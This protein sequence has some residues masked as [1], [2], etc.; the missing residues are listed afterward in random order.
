MNRNRLIIIV[1]VV[2]LLIGLGWCN[3][4][5]FFG[6]NLGKGA[7]L[8]PK[9]VDIVTV[10][11]VP[12]MLSK[13]DFDAIQSSSN[14]A[15]GLANITV[16]NPIFAEIIKDPIAAG[17]NIENPAFVTYHR[18]P[19]EQ[20]GNYSVFIF[21]VDNAAAL[22][23]MVNKATLQEKRKLD[24]YTA[25]DIDRLSTVGWTNKYLVFIT[26]DLI[27]DLDEKLSSYL[28]NSTQNSILQEPTFRKAL[29]QKGEML[30]WVSLSFIAENTSLT[31]SLGLG[32]V[33]P[34]SFD[35]N[36]VIGGVDFGRGQFSGNAEFLFK[37]IIAAGLKTF[38]R[39]DF[40]SD[41]AKFV[42]D[43]NRGS[44]FLMALNLPNMY[45]IALQSPDLKN[46]L[47]DFLKQQGLEID[48]LFRI[49]SGDLLFVNYYPPGSPVATPFFATKIYRPDLLQKYLDVA[50]KNGAIEKVAEGYYGTKL[51]SQSNADSVAA[52][53]DTTKLRNYHIILKEDKLMF[54]NNYD[55]METIYYGGYSTQQQMKGNTV[56]MMRNRF[57]YGEA[58]F[59]K[60]FNDP[61]N[62]TDEY[63]SF[64][65][66][67]S[68]TN[69][70]FEMRF[71]DKNA[72]TLQQTVMRSLNQ[73]GN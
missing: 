31:Q 1:L 35:G 23:Q 4:N 56:E 8:I 42:S 24:G 37:P 39:D 55:I 5:L 7:E 32:T 40:D 49:L 70:N 60:V 19:A 33:P 6:T 9:D 58:D 59:S 62:P 71:K 61:N 13:L 10:L 66:N 51:V 52:Q 50:E 38:F 65:F 17:L 45:K 14:Y 20:E 26:A 28:N 21:S 36:F 22:E 67:L 16:A 12:E 64:E 25:V 44:T 53:L 46:V 15:S 68:Q 54:T 63:E 69:V 41:F 43:K 27:I 11:D 72:N 57:V 48:Q 18:D 3:R 73:S 2:L 29:E 47:E 34:E 30:F